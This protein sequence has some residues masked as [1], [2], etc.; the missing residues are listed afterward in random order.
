MIPLT[1]GREETFDFTNY[2]WTEHISR[3]AG[4][5]HAFSDELLEQL[6]CCGFHLSAERTVSGEPSEEKA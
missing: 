3:K 6:A 2:G 4:Q 1:G 5:W